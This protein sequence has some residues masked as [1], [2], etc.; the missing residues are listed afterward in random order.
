MSGPVLAAGLAGLIDLELV[1]LVGCGVMPSA[2]AWYSPTS[3]TLWADLIAVA[4]IAATVIVGLK[5][6]P[7]RRLR[8]T[9]VSRTRLMNAP[10]AIRDNLKLSYKDKILADPYVVVLEIASTGRSAIPSSSFDNGRDLQLELAAEIETI[11]SLE[12]KPSSATKPVIRSHGSA[13]EFWPELIA[14]REIIN[15]SVLTEGNPG[16]IEVSLNPFTDVNIEVADREATQARRVRRAGIVLSVLV[17]FALGATGVATYF[18]I[19]ETRRSNAISEST[20]CLTLDEF[21]Q[22]TSLAMQL[23]Y[24]DIAIHRTGKGTIQFIHFSP[25]YN[26]DVA[27]LR[28]VGEFLIAEYRVA[29]NPDSRR[30]ATSL[31]QVLDVL[32]KLP[33]EGTGNAVNRDIAEFKA[34]MNQTLNPNEH[35]LGC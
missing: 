4:G 35:A 30:A 12:Y 17:V 29:D 25:Q 33:R 28:G 1:P 8:C 2:A 14:R 5:V 23:V 19:N 22:T 6:L 34:V 20:I 21:G 11:L 7:R 31:T 26:A 18:N 3:S 10:Q 15:I 24:R 13:V 27:T 32:P 16:S 9:V